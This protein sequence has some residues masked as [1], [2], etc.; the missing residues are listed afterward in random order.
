MYD[1]VL[2][3]K[4]VKS[5]IGAFGGDPNMVTIFGESAGAAS[6]GLHL[7]SPLSEPLF[8][9]AILQSGAPDANWAVMTHAQSR[10]RSETLGLSHGCDDFED[11]DF[12][13][14]LRCIPA[15]T[16]S[17]NE[18]VTGNFNEFPWVPVV[19]NKF[20]TDE[21]KRLIRNGHFKK[22]SIMAGVNG[23]EGTYFILYQIPGYEI[24]TPSYQ[25]YDNYLGNVDVVNYDLNMCSR[26][27]IKDHYSHWN[28][29]YDSVANRDALDDVV[30]DRQFICPTVDFAHKYAQENVNVYTYKL[31]IRD[32]QNPWPQWM[33]IMHGDDIQFVF[34]MPLNPANGYTDEEVELSENIM[35]YW[36]NFAKSGNPNKGQLVP[37][38]PRQTAQGRQYL[39]FPTF[40]SDSG[41]RK[42]D[43]QLWSELIPLLERDER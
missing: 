2:A 27:A 5:N 41:L 4:W 43:C 11:R 15:D 7:L 6:V 19:D 33:G 22:A 42:E 14:C 12:V 40:E 13:D 28:M 21:P 18:W 36:A 29:L 31:D 34:G 32:S 20:L 39:R 25:T 30:G 17:A 37:Y 10:Q 35:A 16:L 38:W 8:N 24:D 3:L 1:Q 9:R 23:D 26:S